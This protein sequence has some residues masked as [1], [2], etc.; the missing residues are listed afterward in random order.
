MLDEFDDDG[1]IYEDLT[2]ESDE[3]GIKVAPAIDSI[4][5]DNFVQI[6]TEREQ[7]SIN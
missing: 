7:I 5:E 3:E 6:L 2:I 1:Y 4:I